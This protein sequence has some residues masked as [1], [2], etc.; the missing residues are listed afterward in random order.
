M[1][2]CRLGSQRASQAHV[3]DAMV[4]QSSLRIVAS[5][6]MS[7]FNRQA[8]TSGIAVSMGKIWQ[9]A[10][11]LQRI[12]RPHQASRKSWCFLPKTLMSLWLLLPVLKDCQTAPATAN[13]QQA[14]PAS[15]QLTSSKQQVTGLPHKL[16]CCLCWV[17]AAHSGA[18]PP[19][20]CSL[21]RS[22]I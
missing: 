17:P 22:I 11:Q 13:P 7:F 4:S 8:R 14:Q 10:M 5:R 3:Q 18:S 19:G 1:T 12:R 21:R 6:R 16:T 9:M 2:H 15:L 20:G